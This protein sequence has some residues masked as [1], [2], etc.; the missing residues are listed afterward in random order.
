LSE[1]VSLIFAQFVE[2]RL[3]YTRL[4]FLILAQFNLF[5]LRLV[6]LIGNLSLIGIFLVFRHLL[7]STF[8]LPSYFLIP[9]ALII[10]QPCYSFDGSL[11]PAATLAYFPVAGGVFLSLY[12]LSFDTHKAFFYSI[13]AALFATFSFGNG[14]FVWLIGLVLL[15][16]QGRYRQ[17]S[18]WLVVSASTLVGYYMSYQVNPSRPNIFHNLVSFPKY[19]F[20]NVLVFLGGLTE[21]IENYTQLLSKDNLPS[22]AIGFVVV[23]LFGLNVLLYVNHLWKPKTLQP[24][25]KLS[26]T[27][28][29]QKPQMAFLWI[30]VIGFFVLSAVI[31]SVSRTEANI[32]YGHI[33]RYRI[34]S[35]CVVLLCYCFVLLCANQRSWVLSITLLLSAGFSMYNYYYFTYFF[36]EGTCIYQAG[37]YNWN[38]QKQWGIYNET[39]YW[40]PAS[41]A[42][43]EM[44][45]EKAYNIYQLP[46]GLLIEA[47]TATI[48]VGVSVKKLPT[49][50]N[51]PLIV[52]IRN[53]TMIGQY[54]NPADGIYV[55]LKSSKRSLLFAGHL[56]RMPLKNYIQTGKYYDSGFDFELNANKFPVG[57]Y[58]IG[59]IQRQKDKNTF[60]PTSQTIQIP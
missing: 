49:A 44:F 47:D 27:I 16:L 50:A 5:D 19:I 38:N 60:L 3:G 41:K 35:V 13:L 33:N 42:I 10:F 9:V 25:T 53:D 6:V 26:N 23:F 46:K 1:K 2:H 34:H 56:R 37:L 39:D 17:F 45:E 14:Q 18:V 24:L 8:R 7:C 59:I 57:T 58:S 40:E 29:N 11:W 48:D 4:V 36:A 20:L 43:T 22:L 54:T 55:L 51:Q 21:R 32:I 31:F 12:L 28:F 30:G 15:L 52:S